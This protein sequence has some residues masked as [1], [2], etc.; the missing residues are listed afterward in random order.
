MSVNYLKKFGTKYT[1]GQFFWAL[2]GIIFIVVGLIALISLPAVFRESKKNLN[3]LIEEN[4]TIISNSTSNQLAEMNK[5]FQ[6]LILDP[7]MQTV[8]N[9]L[10]EGKIIPA[11]QALNLFYTFNKYKVFNSLLMDVSFYN[12]NGEAIFPL[13][14]ESLSNIFPKNKI[15]E[16]WEK[17][18]RTLWNNI[19][20]DD[21]S[22]YALRSVRSVVNWKKVGFIQF[23]VV[24]EALLFHNNRYG[25]LEFETVLLD[26]GK[27]IIAS[28]TTMTT[29][30]K[31]DMDII[32]TKE[33]DDI[34]WTLSISFN[35]YS[36]Y[37]NFYT[38]Q[39]ILLLSLILGGITALFFSI[40]LSKLITR[41]IQDIQK[42]MNEVYLGNYTPNNSEYYNYE[43]NELNKTYNELINKIIYLIHE[44]YEKQQLSH[45]SEIKA[46]QAQINPHFLYNTLEA[47]NWLIREDGGQDKAIAAILKL[48]KLFQ[49]RIGSSKRGDVVSIEEELNHIRQYLDIIKIRFDERLGISIKCDSK[50]SEF[51]IPRLSLQPIVENAIS[52][53]I[54]DMQEGGNVD[55]NIES[56]EIEIKITISDNGIG[57]RKQK[58]L[59]LNK[60][61]RLGA[62]VNIKSTDE[63]SNGV[64]LLNVNK[65]LLLFFEKNATMKLF[66]NKPRGTIVEIVIKN[67]IY[68]HG[69]TK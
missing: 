32:F 2:F 44:V 31:K 65:R 43:I 68:R 41:P 45:Q 40:Y 3:S 54:E 15:Y 25:D 6:L 58:L 69:E 47:I 60:F 12:S 53:G 36:L 19:S 26:S 4:L 57:I 33:I 11:K 61:L 24:P 39:K 8:I 21:I 51:Q 46:L 55:I 56:N 22:L 17:P 50:A 59:E 18:N 42:I 20:G 34:F 9:L 37:S 48:S 23:K 1:R 49:Y 16:A 7:D 64:G 10:S 52:H 63:N 28:S 38:L 66:N 27:N 29:T 30:T 67:G 5:T 62:E 35:R 13:G 14:G